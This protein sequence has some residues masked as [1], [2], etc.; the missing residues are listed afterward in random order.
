MEQIPE[1]SGTNTKEVKV[2]KTRRNAAIRNSI[3]DW[4]QIIAL[5]VA[6]GWAGYTFYY[7]KIYEPK[8]AII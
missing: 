8:S 1:I 2:K 7:D 3:K 4:L 6:A 5:L